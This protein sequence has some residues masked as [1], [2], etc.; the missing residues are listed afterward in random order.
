MNQEG[1][2]YEDLIQNLEEAGEPLS[3]GQKTA[4]FLSGIQDRKYDAYKTVCKSCQ[5][6]FEKCV[7]ELRQQSTS[8]ITQ[9]SQSQ[10]IRKMNYNNRSYDDNYN[11]LKLPDDI[12]KHLS[13]EQREAYKK[14]LRAIKNNKT[15]NE[16]TNMPKRSLNS[17]TS[18]NI[19][20]ELPEL[21]EE[22][23]DH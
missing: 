18:T 20:Q 4:F 12:W 22:T 10:Q 7:L 13:Q 11:D 19:E 17:S 1:S 15:N 9:Y 5:Y 21:E 16:E 14:A 2:Q 6:D 3:S 23:E 8:G